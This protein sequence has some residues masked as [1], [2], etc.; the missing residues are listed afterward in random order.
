MA[1]ICASV[2]MHVLF[3]SVTSEPLS[4]HTA[5]P[6]KHSAAS[7]DTEDNTVVSE[8]KS[9]QSQRRLTTPRAAGLA[10]VISGV[11][12]IVSHVLILMSLPT[13]PVVLGANSLDQGV[14]V[15]IALQCLPFA[16]I[17]FLW[18]MG[19]A[20]HRL[21]KREDQFYA[22]VFL[23]SGLLY[24]AMTFVATALAGGLW[25]Y[26]AIDEAI[27]G[28]DVYDVARSL[29]AQITNLYGLR[30]ASVFML[31]AAAM[32][33]RTQVMPRWLAVLTA[34]LAL[35]LL[36]TVGW[37]LWAALLFPGWMVVV[38]LL[39]LISDFRGDVENYL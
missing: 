16:G 20:R 34:V 24:L 35:T 33:F 31:S 11:L 39:I 3:R 21:G 25:A 5:D 19:V 9:T 32:W 17:A 36:L 26:Y 6:D 8:T 12:F 7:Q 13:D 18:F 30:M 27:A 23:G 28:E 4:I 15:T 1:R 22:T 38:S 2:S 14:V 29:V 10:G 37:S